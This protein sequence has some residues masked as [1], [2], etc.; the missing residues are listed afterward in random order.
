VTG[1]IGLGKFIKDLLGNEIKL[2]D[3]KGNIIKIEDAKDKVTFTKDNAGKEITVKIDNGSEQK[4]VFGI[5]L[6]E[7]TDKLAQELGYENA[8]AL[9]TKLS[10]KSS[11]T[12]VT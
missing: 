7:I 10:N 6:N 12:A 5:P 9:I 1:S 3:A 11:K 4:I 2:T 8:D